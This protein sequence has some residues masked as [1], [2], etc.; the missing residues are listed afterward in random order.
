MAWPRSRQPDAGMEW[1]PNAQWTRTVAGDVGS[2]KLLGEAGARPV[3]LDLA[4]P[5]MF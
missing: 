3:M 4:R 2:C 5:V 1:R